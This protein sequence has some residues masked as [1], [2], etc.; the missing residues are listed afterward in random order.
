MNTIIK[1]VLVAVI[2]MLSWSI[3]GYVVYSKGIHISNTYHQ[4][5]YQN[6]AQAQITMNWFMY[7]GEFK[8][9]SKRVYKDEIPQILATLN[10]VQYVL[11]KIVVDS[12]IVVMLYYP[13]MK[14]DWSKR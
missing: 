12:G 4:E 9:I 3:T 11:C 2:L 13:E 5:Q 7:Q 10:P 8:V 1:W 14:E 6:Q